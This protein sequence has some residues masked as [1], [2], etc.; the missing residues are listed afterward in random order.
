MY[1]EKIFYV[2]KN[3]S[4]KLC[5]SIKTT[6]IVINENSLVLLKNIDKDNNCDNIKNIFESL[7]NMVFTKVFRH[8]WKVVV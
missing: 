6:L 3:S 1:N 4:H 2:Q 7:N 8:F 5:S